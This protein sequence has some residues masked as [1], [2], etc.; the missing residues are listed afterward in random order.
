MAVK[1]MQIITYGYKLKGKNQKGRCILK[2]ASF[3]LNEVT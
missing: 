1:E 3:L 2:N